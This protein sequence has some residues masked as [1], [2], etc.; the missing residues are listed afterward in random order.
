M[1]ATIDHEAVGVLLDVA[2]PTAGAPYFVELRHLGGA[3]SRPPKVANAIGRRDGRFALYTGSEATPAG[4]DGLRDAHRRFHTAMSAWATGGVCPN[5]LSGPDVTSEELASGY[6]P[7]DFTRLAEI[8]GRYDPDN[9]FR[10]N[11]NI[12][13]AFVDVAGP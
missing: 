1:L 7:S 11:H 8:K 12:P 13:R 6:L 3:F 9:T 4:L 10:I 5:F 2:G